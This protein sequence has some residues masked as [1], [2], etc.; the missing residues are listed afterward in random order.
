MYKYMDIC[1]VCYLITEELMDRWS[2]NL[3]YRYLKIMVCQNA[4]FFRTFGP[5]WGRKSDKMALLC[6]NVIIPKNENRFE[7]NTG[8]LM[9]QSGSFI[10]SL[11]MPKS[12][13]N[14]KPCF[15]NNLVMYWHQKT[16]VEHESVS[17]SDTPKEHE[18]SRTQSQRLPG[19]RQAHSAS[20]ITRRQARY[21]SIIVLAT[22]QASKVIVPTVN[23]TAKSWNGRK[24][25]AAVSVSVVVQTYMSY[26]GD[27]VWNV[28]VIYVHWDI[29]DRDISQ[30][31]RHTDSTQTLLRL[32]LPN[33]WFAKL[34]Q[35]GR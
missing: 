26:H 34:F 6:H 25:S 24:L 15:I 11:L 22:T 13:L 3:E 31:L 21:L 9:L 33:Q 18:Y 4:Y 23:D 7:I 30:C 32:A 27:E 17:A 12:L 35:I 10:V 14:R 20:A 1:F 2:S 5:S 8:S 29:L 28:D 16:Q 19:S